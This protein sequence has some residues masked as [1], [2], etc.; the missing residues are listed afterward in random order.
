MD[1]PDV[2]WISAMITAIMTEDLLGS[3]RIFEVTG[4]NHF[5]GIAI[6][7]RSDFSQPFLSN[8][9]TWSSRRL[10]S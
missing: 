10:S 2:V 6:L 8:A 9:T 1:A 5:C 7:V 3:S 4:S